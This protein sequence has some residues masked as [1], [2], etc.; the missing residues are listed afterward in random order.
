MKKGDKVRCICGKGDGSIP[1]TGEVYTI[2]SVT[3]RT[4]AQVTLKEDPDKGRWG[5][6]RF[7][8]VES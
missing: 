1:K 5:E 2:E 6:V 4:H 7:E 8:S 3:G